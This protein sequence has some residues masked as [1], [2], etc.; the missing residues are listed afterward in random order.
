MPGAVKPLFEAHV[1]NSILILSKC[2][3]PSRSTKDR[4]AGFIELPI[5]PSASGWDIEMDFGHAV[6]FNP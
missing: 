4:F 3:L 5:L 1:K 6:A 2:F